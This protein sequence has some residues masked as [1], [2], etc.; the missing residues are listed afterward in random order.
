MQELQ[1]MG[2][3]KTN[4]NLFVNVGAAIIEDEDTPERRQ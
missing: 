3:R 2:L 1:K 4:E